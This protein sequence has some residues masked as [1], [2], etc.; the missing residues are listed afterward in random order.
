MSE[1]AQLTQE[2]TQFFETGGETPLEAA[3][4]ATETT[5]EAP[6]PEVEAQIETQAEPAPKPKLVPLEA[7]H[8]ARGMTKQ[9]REQLQRSEQSRQQMEARLQ[10]MMER[11]A[12]PA[13]QA[14]AF[15]ENPAENLRH[16]VTQTKAQ[17]EQ[18][19]THQ[20]QQ[21]QEQQFASWYQNEAARFE[22]QTPDF[23][24]AYNSFIQARASE[25]ENAGL[26]AAEIAKRVRQEEMM[27]AT[28][29]AQVGMNPAQLIYQTAVSKGYKR[30][31][32]PAPQTN[33]L[34]QVA[35]GIKSS[36]SLSQVR[37]SAPENLTLEYLANMPDH[38]FRQFSN[39]DKWAETMQRLM[40]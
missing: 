1:E 36:K 16:E 27:L 11:L 9:L 15:D 32:A 40:G 30:A 26:P 4:E 38:E 6:Q 2:E 21:Q 3:P 23:R 35:N 33:K 34:E 25:L 14:P 28:T 37:G 7:L 10:Q 13:P 17:L 31:Q 19:T 8:E 5:Q 12:P 39:D 29:A 20:R 18:L 24:D 22:S